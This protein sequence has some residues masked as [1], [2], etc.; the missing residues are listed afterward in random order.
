MS[1]S[2]FNVSAIGFKNLNEISSLN[3]IKDDIKNN[4]ITLKSNTNTESYELILPNNAPHLNKNYLISDNNGNLTWSAPISSEV[5]P[6]EPSGPP[7]IYSSNN[8]YLFSSQISKMSS[9]KGKN[10]SSIIFNENDDTI[11]INS[12]NSFLYMFSNVI[13]LG[14]NNNS[15]IDINQDYIIIKKPLIIGN[16]KLEVIND[17]LIIT[18]FDN[19]LQKYIPGVIVI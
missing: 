18:K 13:S 12:N 11:I 15:S 19:N 16:Y 6:T 4:R 7:L 3:N 9:I 17:E 10:N 1:T 5:L 2:V 14:F 8:E